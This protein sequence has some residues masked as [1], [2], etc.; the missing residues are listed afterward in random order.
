MK[1][2]QDRDAARETLQRIIDRFPDSE[3]SLLAAQRIASLASTEHLLAPHD[4][5]KFTVVEGVQNLGL[6]DP[7]FHLQ[8]ASVDAA[9]Q[10]AE[11]VT[12]LQSHPLDGEAREKL[13]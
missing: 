10:A 3:F 12:H 9:K 11:L 5:K 1:F 4:R 6:L 13:A 7:K 8:P 2:N